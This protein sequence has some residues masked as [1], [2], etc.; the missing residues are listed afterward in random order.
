MAVL[1]IDDL[2][3]IFQGITKT[4]TGI[5]GKNVRISYQPN[6]QP[7]WEID[8]NVLGLYVEEVDN[9]YNKQRDNLSFGEDEIT[10]IKYT[11][12]FQVSW[13]IYGPDSYTNADNIRFNIL[14]ESIRSVLAQSEIYPITNIKAPG[15]APYLYNGRWW[16][17]ADVQVLFNVTTTRTL[18]QSYLTGAVVKIDDAGGTARIIEIEE[19]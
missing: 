16:S 1:E 5:P 7:A 19:P 8:Q 15:R 18:D 2:N 9:D 13:V 3:T 14:Q 11:R 6:S 10:I 17:R 4:M 12:V